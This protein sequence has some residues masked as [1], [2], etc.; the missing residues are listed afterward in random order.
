MT[1]TSQEPLYV[2]AGGEPALR[3]VVTDFYERVFTDV[4]IGFFF[5]GLDKQRLIDKETELA[6]QL[7]GADVEYTGRPLR[8]AHA[9]HRIMGGQFARRLQILRETMA[10]HGLPPEVQEAWVRHTEALRDQV[11]ADASG[12]CRPT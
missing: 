4:M 9:S 7:L 6:L 2:R 3:A 11:T 1:I 8:A 12:E 5:K 10:D